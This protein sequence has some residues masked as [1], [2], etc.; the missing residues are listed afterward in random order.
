[1]N[2][3]S[4]TRLNNV[5]RIGLFLMILS[6][7]VGILAHSPWTGYKVY[8]PSMETDFTAYAAASISA[9]NRCGEP[10]RVEGINALKFSDLDRIHNCMKQFAPA[11]PVER[12][13]PFSEWT[14]YQPII[15]WFGNILNLL[16]FSVFAS[17]VAGAWVVL[18]SSSG[19]SK[20]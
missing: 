9:S 1:M 18:F 12:D 20:S 13:L 7:G 5:Q 10:T 16:M 2:I 4:L 15:P 19:K 17:V 14:T 3:D 11:E 6:M 8:A